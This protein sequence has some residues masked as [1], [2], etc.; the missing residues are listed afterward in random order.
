MVI[1]TIT[2]ELFFS[3]SKKTITCWR[4]QFL[5]WVTGYYNHVYA[6]SHWKASKNK[7]HEDKRAEE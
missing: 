2:F 3:I 5:F 7:N 1:Q 4:N 6:N